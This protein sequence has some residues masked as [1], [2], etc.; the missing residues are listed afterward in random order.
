MTESQTR[1][2]LTYD[3]YPIWIVRVK[4]QLTKLKLPITDPPMSV[5]LEPAAQKEWEEKAKLALEVQMHVSDALLPDILDLSS[6]QEIFFF[7]EKRYQQQSTAMQLQL[8]QQL[9]NLRMQPG[10]R[11]NAFFTRVRKLKQQLTTSGYPVSEQE[12]RLSVHAALPRTFGAVLTHLKYSSDIK[13]WE[14]MEPILVTEEPNLP[15]A[16]EATAHFVRSANG[17]GRG[18]HT[19]AGQRSHSKGRGQSKPTPDSKQQVPGTDGRLCK[20]VRCHGCNQF[21]HYRQQC[22]KGQP[23]AAAHTVE[24]TETV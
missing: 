9:N 1:T 5:K 4:G 8:R 7:F 16:N 20:G 12:L 13:T 22:P 11:V 15:A 21:G 23:N 18:Q 14:D 19:P 17:R 6:V 24:I 10:E 2:L 3:N